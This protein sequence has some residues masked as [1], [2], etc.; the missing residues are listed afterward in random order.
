MDPSRL[1]LDP[2]DCQ[3][4]DGV[5]DWPCAKKRLISSS[6]A[7]SA[8]IV[9]FPKT[10]LQREER[11]H[12]YTEDVSDPCSYQ[13]LQALGTNPLDVQLALRILPCTLTAFK[14]NKTF[15]AV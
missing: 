10:H 4:G 3:P 15:T 12:V 6:L 14:T 8:R 5:R 2:R 7:N 13:G 9:V 11:E 1:W